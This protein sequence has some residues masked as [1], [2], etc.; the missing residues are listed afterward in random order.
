MKIRSNISIFTI[1]L[2]LVSIAL[3]AEDEPP[4]PVIHGS[5]EVTADAIPVPGATL[6]DTESVRG[7]T[8]LGDGSEVLRDVAGATLGRMGGHGLEPFIRGLSQ[9]DLTVLLDGATVHGGCPNRMDPATSFGT[10]ETTDQVVVIRGVQTLR[11]GGAPG[12]TIL[13]ERTAPEANDEWSA[14]VTAGG[15]SWSA[16]P[17]LAFDLTSSG[18]PWSLRILG[19][20]RDTDNYEDGDGREVRSAATSLSATLLA[21]WRPDERTL[22]QLSY[23]HTRTD[24]ALFGGAGMDAPEDRAHILRFTSERTATPDAVGWDVRTF[25]NTVDHLMNNYELRPLTAPMAM[26]VPTETET[27]GLRGHLVF[28]ERQPLLVGIL[29]ESADADATRFAGPDGDRLSTVQSIMWPDVTRAQTGAFVEAS[30]VLGAHT[31]LV[32]GLRVDHFTAESGRADEATMGG[33]GPT[34]RMLWSRYTAGVDD[35]W[36]DTGVGGLVRFEV[37]RGPWRYH[38]GLSRT[39]RAADATERFLAANS[40]MAPRR[41]IGNPSLEL[42]IHHQLDVGAGWRSDTASVMV[43]AFAA[44]VTDFILRDRA[45]GQG[46]VLQADGA[47]IYR[48][49]D[50]RRHGAE[51]EAFVRLSPTVHLAGTAAWVW[52]ENTTDDRPIAQTPPLNGRLTMGWAHGRFDAGGTLRWAAEQNR[53]DDDPTTGSGLDAGPTDAWTVL[54]LT[55]GVDVGRG[56]GLTLGVANVFDRTYATHLNRASLFDPDPVRVNE[57]GRTWWLRL[58]WRGEG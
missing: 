34:P 12:G 27:W 46:G 13:F 56:F 7:T 36:S 6:L 45:R 54:D 21:G 53:V 18:G 23:E 11:H 10:L 20:Y 5:V 49:V 42:A 52:A 24:D 3:G 16:A 19:S 29:F 43:T 32:G 17:D 30:A 40:S 58:R 4:T 9:G 47:T 37:D 41:W 25:A 48:N 14:D 33:N 57:P 15:T 39:Q 8:P 26:E 44:D 51:A 55:G 22:H 2:I 38:A 35:S 1:S 50:A 28:G 31:R